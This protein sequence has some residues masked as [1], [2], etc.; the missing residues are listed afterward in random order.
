MVLAIIA[1]KCLLGGNGTRTVRLPGDTLPTEW[2][3][4]TISCNCYGPLTCRLS[5]NLAE[6]LYPSWIWPNKKA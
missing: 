2:Q 4:H 6:M 1:E 5:Y 3:M